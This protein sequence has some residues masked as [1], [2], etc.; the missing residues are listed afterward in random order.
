LL[1]D[2]QHVG[3]DAATVATSEVLRDC[4]CAVRDGW[5]TYAARDVL[6]TKSPSVVGSKHWQVDAAVSLVASCWAVEFATPVMADEN[7]T[8]RA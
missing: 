3:L 8:L 7:D 1:R 4:I 2:E 6:R 5:V